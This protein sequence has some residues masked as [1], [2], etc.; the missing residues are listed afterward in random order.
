LGILFK[1]TSHSVALY[2]ADG[3]VILLAKQLFPI[4]AVQV[5]ANP[6]TVTDGG[7]EI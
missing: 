6:D 7:K 1:T 4:D 2:L 3:V 5:I